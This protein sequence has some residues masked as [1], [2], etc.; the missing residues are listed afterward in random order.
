LSFHWRTLIMRMVWAV[1]AVDRSA[2]IPRA[3]LA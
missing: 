3:D 1:L 2:S